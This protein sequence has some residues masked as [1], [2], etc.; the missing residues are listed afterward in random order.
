M[1]GI[2]REQKGFLIKLKRRLYPTEI[3]IR[4]I[5][6]FIREKKEDEEL[7]RTKYKLQSKSLWV[8]ILESIAGII[9][10]VPKP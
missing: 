7:A 3:A 1:N 10:K 9:M 6:E 5:W 2:S 4:R 8:R